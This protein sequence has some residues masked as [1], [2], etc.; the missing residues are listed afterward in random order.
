MWELTKLRFTQL[1]FEN[2]GN[3]YKIQKELSFNQ[4]F[5]QNR[6]FAAIIKISI[7]L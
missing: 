3:Y 6:C 2:C 4:I 7:P 1:N 5:A